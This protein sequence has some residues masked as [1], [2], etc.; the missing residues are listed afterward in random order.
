MNPQNDLNPVN[1]DS[2][3]QQIS[4]KDSLKGVVDYL[5]CPQC[6][7]I[8]DNAVETNCC[9]IVY[10][11][12]CLA[13]RVGKPCPRC[14]NDSLSFDPSIMARRMVGAIETE[15]PYNCG[16]NVARSELKAHK[17]NCL[18]KIVECAGKDCGFKGMK[19]EF[20]EHV[21]K[22][23]Q[24]EI[25]EKFTNKKDFGA[26][27]T[28]NPTQIVVNSRGYPARI[29]SVSKYYCGFKTEVHCGCTCDGHCGPGDG[30]N[31][32][33]CMELDIQSR[34]LGKGNL[35]NKDGFTAI[36]IDSKF[37]CGRRIK[38]VFSANSNCEPAST[39]NCN[40]CKSLDRSSKGL[41]KDL[42]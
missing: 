29:G 12:S 25:I 33:A 4:H 39:S 35:V 36:L 38:G 2:V 16:A 27:D 3:Y 37:Y 8:A 21:L 26:V 24:N 30:C 7:D 40:A 42:L 32:A 11:E 5:I 17:S 18:K 23:H 19:D 10:C 14:K 31:C 22:T 15:C 34:K 13:S 1:P 20:T 9:H 6:S 41:Y 28:S